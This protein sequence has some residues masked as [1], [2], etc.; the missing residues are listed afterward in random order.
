LRLSVRAH[1]GDDAKSLP[2]EEAEEVAELHGPSHR[3]RP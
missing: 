1:R 3:R 2:P